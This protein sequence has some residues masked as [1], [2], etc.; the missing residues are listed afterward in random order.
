[1]GFV[2]RI[3]VGFRGYWHNENNC[4]NNNWNDSSF[5]YWSF[6]IGE[7]AKQADTW[8]DSANYWPRDLHYK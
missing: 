1:M 7:Q 8:R 6:A 5:V 3:Q 2:Q 4:T